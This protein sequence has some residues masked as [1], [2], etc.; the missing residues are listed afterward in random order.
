[1][2][3]TK[4]E[5]ILDKR[6]DELVSMGITLLS[7]MFYSYSAKL[8]GESS[9]HSQ[10]FVSNRF[11]TDAMIL[12][13]LVSAAFELARLFICDSFGL[14]DTFPLKNLL[15]PKHFFRYE[16]LMKIPVP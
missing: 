1:M 10:I 7:D 12:V 11:R 14:L 9:N 4:T 2:M 8:F 5:E 16:Q 6:V 3:N 15:Q 13:V